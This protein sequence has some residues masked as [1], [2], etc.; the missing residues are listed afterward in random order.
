[1]CAPAGAAAPVPAPAPQDGRLY[2][3]GVRHVLETDGSV[4]LIAVLRAQRRRLPA[5]TGDVG[6]LCP[7]VA[8]GETCPLG[9]RCPHLHVDAVGRAR[10]RP[11]AVVGPP[12]LTLHR[13]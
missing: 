4:G 5:A 11:C 8:D 6:L 10:R 7:R 1:M 2:T 9:V 13:S 3:V 12:L